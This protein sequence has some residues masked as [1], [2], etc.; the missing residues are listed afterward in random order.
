[1]KK[2]K[3]LDGNQIPPIAFGLYHV[4]QIDMLATIRC[5]YK[6]GYRLFDTASKYENEE[7]FGDAL[8]NLKICRQDIQIASKAWTDEMGYQQVKKALLRSLKRLKMDYLDF[9]FIHWPIRN[10]Q[11]MS[12]TWKAMEEMKEEGLIRSIAVCNFNPYHMYAVEDLKY[13]PVINQVER[14]PL[15]TQKSLISY[16]CSKNIITEAWAPLMRGKKVIELEKI[17]FLAEKYKKTPAQIIMRW[18]I[19]QGIVP[20]TKSV[21]L[22]RIQENI[23]VFDFTLTQDELN[24]IDGLNRNERSMKE[25]PDLYP[26]DCTVGN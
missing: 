10:F 11:K 9:Y 24:E 23:N 5:A 13:L 17:C 20:I 16:N 8:Q 4:K 15:L 14:S 22:S 6:A 7:F 2:I 19:Q 12:E 21:T 3:L 18:N 26:Y 1:M 25:D